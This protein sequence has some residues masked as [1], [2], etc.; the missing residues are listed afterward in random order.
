LFFS[1]ASW[2]RHDEGYLNGDPPRRVCDM[3]F[4]RAM[5]RDAAELRGPVRMAAG[6][7]LAWAFWIT[8]RL[9]GWA[10]YRRP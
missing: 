10:F 4:L 7:V 5:L 8:V 6:G 1:E 9:F 2:Y 3:K